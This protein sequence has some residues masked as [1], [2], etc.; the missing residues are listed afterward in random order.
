MQE[1]KMEECA[2]VSGAGFIPDIGAL[3]INI[4]IGAVSGLICGGPG[5]MIGGAILGASVA[6]GG[7]M[8]ND[9]YQISKDQQLQAQ[10]KK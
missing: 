4:A 2:E 10:L 7:T 1:L 9:A 8:C 3:L 6:A 5:G